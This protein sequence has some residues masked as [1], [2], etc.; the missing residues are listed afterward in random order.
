VKFLYNSYEISAFQ[1]GPNAY[2][3]TLQIDNNPPPCNET[4][5]QFKEKFHIFRRN[6]G[7]RHPLVILSHILHNGWKVSNFYRFSGEDNKIREHIGMFLAQLG[8][9]STMEHMRFRIFL[10]SLLVFGRN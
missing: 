7:L 9:A 6:S 2:A 8:E 5:S 4:L 3:N 10:L 1:R